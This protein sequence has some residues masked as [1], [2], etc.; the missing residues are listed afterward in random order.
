[1]PKV[2]ISLQYLQKSMGD[3]VDFLPADKH[4][5]FLE[6][7]SVSLSVGSQACPKYPKQQ[8]CNIFATSHRKREGL[9]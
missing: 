1:M 7:D 5:S 6:Y 4:E 2:C 3:E 8:I 9:S